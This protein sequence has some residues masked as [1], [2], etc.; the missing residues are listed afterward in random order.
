MA[1][2]SY[3]K[4][5]HIYHTS[6]VIVNSKGRVLMA[7]KE[8]C[9]ILNCKSQLGIKN[10]II[11]DFIVEKD[12]KTMVNAFIDTFYGKKYGKLFEVNM[13]DSNG[14][15]FEVTINFVPIKGSNGE[16]STLLIRKKMF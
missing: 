7:D 12:K 9:E 11:L 15:D 8:F 4:K 6:K 3:I 1:A 5:D 13:I 14:L 10:S 2:I 16:K